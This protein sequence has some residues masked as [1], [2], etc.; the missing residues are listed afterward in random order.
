MVLTDEEIEAAKFQAVI[1]D[2]RLHEH[3]DCVRIAYQWLDAQR[4]VQSPQ[5]RFRALKHMIEHWGGRYVSQADVEVAAF[6]HPRIRGRYPDFNLSGRLVKPSDHC[7][8]EIG[9]AMTQVNY[10]EQLAEDVYALIEP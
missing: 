8:D 10:R 1:T 4:T 7:L 2:D 3:P 9:E 5:R 6:L